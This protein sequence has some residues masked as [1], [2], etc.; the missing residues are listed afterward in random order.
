MTISEK[1]QIFVKSIP[2]IKKIDRYLNKISHLEEEKIFSEKSTIYLVI[3]LLNLYYQRF[4]FPVFKVKLYIYFQ[5]HL[6]L[7]NFAIKFYSDLSEKSI[8]YIKEKFTNISS[9]YFTISK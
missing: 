5:N 3:E 6:N 2:S 7:C 1:I 9:N 8:E 4:D